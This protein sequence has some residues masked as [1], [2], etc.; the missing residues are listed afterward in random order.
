MFIIELNDI[1]KTYA[2]ATNPALNGINLH[3]KNESIFGLLGPNGAGK[4]TTISL[5]SGLIKADQGS[6]KIFDKDLSQEL[7]TIKKQIGIVPQEY[8][9]F[10][11]LTC[12]ENLHYFGNLYGLKGASLKQKIQDYL[13]LFGLEKNADKLISSFSGGMKRRVN[14]I[15]GILHD[16]KLIILDEP[17]VGVD[18]Q[19]RKLIID[20]LKDYQFKN[21]ISILYTSHHLEEAQDLCD[22]VA[23][24]DH[25]KI[26]VQ[27]TPNKLIEE[28][29]VD[30]LE[31][32]FINLTGYSVRE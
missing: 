13:K 10:P 4:S 8:A 11:T 32:L 12:F 1:Y 20:F 21:K 31:S 25:G 19:S 5:L 22:E 7:S 24:I 26:I 30:N 28:N 9:L 14:L 17:T 15:A 2:N 3:I 23:I 18:V 29:K 27:G 6:I 16:P